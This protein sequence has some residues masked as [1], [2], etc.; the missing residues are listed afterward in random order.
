MI[1]TRTALLAAGLLVIAAVAAAQQPYAGLQQRPVK[2]LSDQQISDLQAGRGMSLALAAELNG[3]PGPRHVLDLAETLQLSA[4]QRARTEALFA[5]MQ[6]EARAIGA[7]IIR[8]ETALDRLF[9]T[10]TASPDALRDLVTDL[11]QRQGAL[12][13][14]HLTYHLAMLELLTPEQT[15]HY[16][17]LRGY[18]DDAAPA[19][20][21]MHHH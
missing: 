6:S 8:G 4:D 21:G 20:H 2:A 13:L 9:A 16:Q 19:G 7:D 18:A 11:G 1:L 10:K 17:L 15:A 12:R 14:A 3:Y 5:A